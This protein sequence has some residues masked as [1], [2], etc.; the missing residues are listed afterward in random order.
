MNTILLIEDDQD[1]FLLLKSYAK[2]EFKITHCPN[3]ADARDYL[4]IKTPDLILLDIDFEKGNGIDFYRENKPDWDHRRIPVV[5]LTQD[6]KLDTKLQ[7][8]ELGALDYISKPFEPLEVIARCNIILKRNK[9]QHMLVKN[10]LIVN[11]L[12]ASVTVDAKNELV[13]LSHLE[14]KLLLFFIENEGIVF[15][16]EKLIERVWGGNISITPRTVDQHVS[17]LR[18]KISE[19]DAEIVTSHGEGYMFISKKKKRPSVSIDQ[20]LKEIIP[21]YLEN[22]KREIELIKKALGTNDFVTLESI[23]HRLAGSAKSY[24]FNKLTEIGLNIQEDAR[25]KSNEGIHHSLQLL[26]EYLGNLSVIYT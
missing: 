23:G 14:F 3:L 15:S 20:E 26:E 22:R 13:D 16:R 1:I 5:M 2:E 17:K 24:G 10:G 25:K 19:A 11:L 6:T 7:S 21:Q 4:K 18:K 8:F 12:T 9:A